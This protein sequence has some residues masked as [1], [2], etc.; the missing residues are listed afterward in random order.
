MVDHVGPRSKHMVADQ[1]A[2]LGHLLTTI[3]RHNEAREHYGRAA[4]I[5]QGIVHNRNVDDSQ[6][7]EALADLADS[8][9]EINHNDEARESRV[10]AAAIYERLA[11]AD[12]GVR[13]PSTS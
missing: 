10:K 1:A 5:Y 11:D 2:H 7:A 9:E 3:D 4:Q 13:T 8:L 12:P 6:R